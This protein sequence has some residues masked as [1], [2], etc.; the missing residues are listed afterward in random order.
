MQT[1]S[2]NIVAHHR[3]FP[4]MY[5]SDPSYRRDAYKVINVKEGHILN[6][7]VAQTQQMLSWEAFRPLGAHWAEFEA[8]AN[9]YWADLHK[10]FEYVGFIHYD[11]ELRLRKK[12]FTSS[13]YVQVTDAIDKATAS[14]QFDHISF[15][16]VS[17]SWD[18]RQRILADPDKPEQLTGRGL[19]AYERILDDYNSY[20]A[21]RYTEETLRVS[22][23]INV[24]SSFLVKRDLFTRLMEFMTWVV[25]TRGLDSL[26]QLRRHRL[27]GGL[28][29]R[30]VGVFL[31]FNAHRSLDLTLR[32]HDL[33]TR[34]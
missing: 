23:R 2:V 33:K 20:F 14:S 5:T 32:H 31:A 26:D 16:S 21:T 4:E 25:E 15:A 6:A 19:S 29:E 18:I 22:K 8:I 12:R 9:F 24:C 13:K 30:Y 1:W 34:G 7:D 28:A 11:M 10:E 17:T 3:L 27:Q